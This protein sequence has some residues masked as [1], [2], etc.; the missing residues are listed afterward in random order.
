[1]KKLTLPTL[2]TVFL[3]ISLG[4]KA[5]V[6]EIEVAPN[7][8]N[9]ESRGTVVTVHTDISFGFVDVSTCYLNGIFIK[10]YKADSR[11]FFVAKFNIDDVKE[12]E[13]LKINGMN[14]LI[15]TGKEKDGNSFSGSQEIQVIKVIPK[16]K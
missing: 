11:G 12:L 7:V 3:L 5:Q 13:G 2:L 6:V 16:G 14:T 1:M 4:L 10:S 15:L 9:I 8:I